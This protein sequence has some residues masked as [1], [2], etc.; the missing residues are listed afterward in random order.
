[1]I[2]HIDNLI[3]KRALHNRISDIGLYVN[4]PRDRVAE[5]SIY[6]AFERDVLVVLN[7]SSDDSSII[8]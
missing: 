3:N 6:Y 8:R 7:N 1:M 5:D 2:L 4:A